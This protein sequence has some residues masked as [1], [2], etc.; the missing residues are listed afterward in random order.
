MFTSDKVY[1]ERLKVCKGCEFYE[2]GWCGTPIVGT[3]VD[4]PEG[5][6][7]KRTCG[8]NVRLKAQLSWE[9]CGHPYEPKWQSEK[10][11]DE[12]KINE[13][14]VFVDELGNRISAK[15]KERL[16]RYHAEVKGI[17]YKDTNCVPCVIERLKEL[18]QLLSQL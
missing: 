8:C 11:K 16:L 7:R 3:L 4:N 6:R 14:K 1:R 15:E 9:Q 18:K 2:R 12:A 5:G 17:E 13:M 10:P